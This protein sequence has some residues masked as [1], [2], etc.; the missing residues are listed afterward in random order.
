MMAERIR[1]ISVG[2]GGDCE[3]DIGIS[4][5]FSSSIHSEPSLMNTSQMSS[6]S[7]DSQRA[8]FSKSPHNLPSKRVGS[9]KAFLLI[10]V[11]NRF[12]LGWHIIMSLSEARRVRSLSLRTRTTRS[13]F[14]SS[15]R[16]QTRHHYQFRE[17]SARRHAVAPALV[18]HQSVC[19]PI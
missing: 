12:V 15:H 17:F 18:H 1:T 10:H 6:S 19:R 11:N 4:D 3:S 7:Q 16:R 14:D 2:G 5:I 9:D 8:N 13:N